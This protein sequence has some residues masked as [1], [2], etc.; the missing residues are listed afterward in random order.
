MHVNIYVCFIFAIM[1]FNQTINQSII[2]RIL[3]LF[4]K[5]Y[6]A[7]SK[8]NYLLL[9]GLFSANVDFHLPATRTWMGRSF[10][11]T[12]QSVPKPLQVHP[13]LHFDPFLLH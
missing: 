2:N 12:F 10:C 11:P 8:N 3:I 5:L 9:Q 6:A 4:V 13:N 7:L 1:V